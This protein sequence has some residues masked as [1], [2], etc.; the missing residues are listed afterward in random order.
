VKD[1][2]P[3]SHGSREEVIT[4]AADGQ[5]KEEEVKLDVWDCVACILGISLESGINI[6]SPNRDG[7]WSGERTSASA[8]AGR[9]ALD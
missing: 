2:T 4:D 8:L 1:G 5:G 7:D 6:L 3:Y 9:V